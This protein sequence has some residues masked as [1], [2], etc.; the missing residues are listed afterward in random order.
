MITCMTYDSCKE[1]VKGLE[2][3]MKD[4]AAFLGN[5]EWRFSFFH[6]LSDFL[7]K[8]AGTDLLDLSCV[9]V[10]QVEVIPKLGEMRKTFQQM[11]LMVIADESVSPMVY[12]K[13]TIAPNALLLR[14]YTKEEAAEVIRELFR[15][16]LEQTDKKADEVYVIE[17]RD[18]KTYLPYHQILY[19]EAREKK[20]FINTGFEEYAVYETI[21]SL[22]EALGEDFVR[23]HR[24]YIVNKN[25]IKKLLLG[26]NLI[27]LEGGHMIP[28]SRSYRNTIKN[29]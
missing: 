29:L 7:E 14:P 6:K 1:E 24:S 22:D 16:Y 11:M 4:E 28:L 23:C 2:E 15:V 26:K 21:D 9:D 5:D 17:A 8:L 25:K 3:M 18:G 13:P 20:V 27:E 10:T 12:L 19:F